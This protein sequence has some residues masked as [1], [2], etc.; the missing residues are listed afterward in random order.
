MKIRIKAILKCSLRS[1]IIYMSHL[2]GSLRLT[3]EI[4]CYFNF[5]CN[6]S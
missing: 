5:Q 1:N 6:W 4:A 2:K 3:S